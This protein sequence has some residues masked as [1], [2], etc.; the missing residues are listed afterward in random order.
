MSRVWLSRNV[1]IP[2]HELEWQFIRSGGAGGQHVNKTSTA[3][4]LIFDI[5]TSS[6]PEYY[7]DRL[8]RYADHRITKA[9]KIVIKCQASRSQL[10]NRQQALHSFI[11]LIQEATR[12]QQKR[13]PTRPTKASKRR[14]LERKKRQGQT[15]QMR[16]KVY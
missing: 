13:R 11:Q 10:E 6:L 15:K 4:Q 5:K 8:L 7:Q 2:E 1:S 9:G 3:A 16:K 12:T 14:R